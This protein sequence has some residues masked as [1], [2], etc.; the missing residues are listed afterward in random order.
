MSCSFEK[1]LGF[2][3]SCF[4]SLYPM[5]SYS[6]EMICS[7][8]EALEEAG[9]EKV[10]IV[11][12]CLYKLEVSFFIEDKKRELK[13]FSREFFVMS[14]DQNKRCWYKMTRSI[15]CSYFRTINL[16]AIEQ[17]QLETD[18]VFKTIPRAF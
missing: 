3:P 10:A 9:Y 17:S 12:E 6:F 13:Y 8:V 5:Q 7:Q 14:N 2:L 18:P 4:V 11:A 16:Y 1:Y 15:G